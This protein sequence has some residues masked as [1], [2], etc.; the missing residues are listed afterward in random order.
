MAPCTLL[1]FMTACIM[2]VSW[3]MTVAWPRGTG[4]SNK[5]QKGYGPVMPNTILSISLDRGSGKCVHCN[6]CGQAYSARHYGMPPSCFLTLFD[7]GPCLL[8]IWAHILDCQNCLRIFEASS[9]AVGIRKLSGDL[10]V[11][12]VSAMKDSDS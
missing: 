3:G 10:L 1:I 9:I 6:M 11:R 5:H 2:Q 8:K 4:C 12:C 7:T